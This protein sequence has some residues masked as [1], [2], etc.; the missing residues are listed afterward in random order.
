MNIIA[1]QN[2]LLLTGMFV[3]LSGCATLAPER[4]NANLLMGKNISEAY[5]VFGRPFM[6]G[7]AHFGKADDPLN[8]QKQYTFVRMGTSYNKNSIVGGDTGYVA[9]EGLVHTDYYQ[10]THVQESCTV[11]LLTTKDN[12]ID[13]YDIKGNCGLWDAGFGNTGALHR[14]GID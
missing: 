14:I 9:G 4:H 13:Y 1:M 10:T 12:I 5:K 2:K 7:T 3:L 6:I 8:G 11:M